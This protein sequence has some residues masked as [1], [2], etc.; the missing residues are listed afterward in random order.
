[1]II[2]LFRG[3]KALFFKLTERSIFPDLSRGKRK[4]AEIILLSICGFVY[5]LLLSKFMQYSF[6][7][8]MSPLQS[9]LLHVSSAML[10]AICCSCSQKFCCILVLSVL[11]GCGKAGRNIVKVLVLF[12]ILTGSIS[13]IVDNSKEVARVFSCSTFLTYNLTKTKLDLMMKPFFNAF[14]KVDLNEVQMNLQQITSVVSPL[15]REVE[16]ESAGKGF[17]HGFHIELCF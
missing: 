9:F 17:V 7:I 5:G 13:N 10:V 12:L 16:G 11:E 2:L 1:M 3:L 4:F 6:K 15:M 14:S 8:N